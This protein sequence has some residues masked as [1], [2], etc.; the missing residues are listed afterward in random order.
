MIRA[1]RPAGYLNNGPNRRRGGPAGESPKARQISSVILSLKT[2]AASGRAVGG[3]VSGAR[4][5]SAATIGPGW[6]RCQGRRGGRPALFLFLLG[7]LRLAGPDLRP[8]AGF[9]DPV[10]A[11]LRPDARGPGPVRLRLDPAAFDPGV[12]DAGPFPVAGDPDVFRARL[13]GE[14]LEPERGRADPGALA[15]EAGHGREA[16]ND[17]YG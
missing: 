15:G 14:G 9:P 4:V 10:V 1:K 2:A 13:E 3:I 5:H 16:E 8:L 6:H 7:G 17:H 12:I 11:H